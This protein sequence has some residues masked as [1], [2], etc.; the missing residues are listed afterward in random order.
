MIR[1]SHCATEAIALGAGA[2][3]GGHDYGVFV[4]YTT[5]TLYGSE[6]P[7]G[8]AAELDDEARALLE[9]RIDLADFRARA[10]HARG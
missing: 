7:T 1:R 9:G 5:R 6:I 3:R 10:A 4:F 2:V 8:T